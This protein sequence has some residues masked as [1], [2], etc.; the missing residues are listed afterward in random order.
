[1]AECLLEKGWLE[2]RDGR[3]GRQVANGLLR[4]LLDALLEVAVVVAAQQDLTLQARGERVDE[5]LAELGALLLRH[6]L[7]AVRVVALDD[8]AVLLEHGVQ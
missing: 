1:M 2:G 3:P 8:A 7:P 4:R 5:L 6:I